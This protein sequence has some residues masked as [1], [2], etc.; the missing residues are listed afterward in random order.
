MCSKHE[1]EIQG[2]EMINNQNVIA[3]AAVTFARL[4]DIFENKIVKL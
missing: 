4:P 3:V 1:G 2:V